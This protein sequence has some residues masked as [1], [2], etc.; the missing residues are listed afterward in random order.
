MAAMSAKGSIT[1]QRHI[2]KAALRVARPVV[3]GLHATLHAGAADDE[4]RRRL[5]AEYCRHLT[6]VLAGRAPIQ[7]TAATGSSL[8]DPLPPRQ[9]QTLLQLL[10]GDSEKQIAHKLGLS[11]NTVHTY[12]KSVYRHFEVNS[13]GELL[14]RFVQPPTALPAKADKNRQSPE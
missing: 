1:R 7:R 10:A 6:T 2:R 9:R 8:L 14:A 4:A 11:R 5:L 12:V 3:G 13:R